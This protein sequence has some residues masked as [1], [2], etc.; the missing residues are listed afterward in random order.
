MTFFDNVHFIKLTLPTAVTVR[1]EQVLLQ[2]YKQGRTKM[3]LSAT[4]GFD[5]QQIT[6]QP[7]AL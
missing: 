1:C 7:L 6:P 2:M 3:H 4:D 5:P